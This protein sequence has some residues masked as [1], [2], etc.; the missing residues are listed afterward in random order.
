MNID[1]ET[2]CL[3]F[4]CVDNLE[5]ELLLM[6][7]SLKHALQDSSTCSCPIPEQ[8]FVTLTLKYSWIL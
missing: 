6:L 7:R 1:K 5:H 3:G 8:S 2:L 4:D